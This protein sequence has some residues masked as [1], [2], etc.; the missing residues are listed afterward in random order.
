MKIRVFVIND[1]GNNSGTL[2]ESGYEQEFVKPLLT[3]KEVRA[4]FNYIESYDPDKQPTFSVNNGGNIIE[5]VNIDADDNIIISDKFAEAI[6]S[7]IMPMVDVIEDKDF[8]E[9]LH[10]GKNI[11]LSVRNKWIHSCT[12]K[13]ACAANIKAEP[14]V[15]EK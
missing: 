13:K 12:Q 15:I 14:K 2:H 8:G 3:E 1:E 4:F 11:Y 10:C 9:C 7:K 6:R 5:F